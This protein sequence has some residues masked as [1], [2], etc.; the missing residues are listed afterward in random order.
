M[1]VSLELHQ[2]VGFE[3]G[4]FFAISIIAFRVGDWEGGWWWG[5]LGVGN[6]VAKSD[7]VFSFMGEVVL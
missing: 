7:K 1:T 6:S 5:W 3:E 2:E 4:K